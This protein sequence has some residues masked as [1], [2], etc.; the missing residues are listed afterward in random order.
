MS[1]TTDDRFWTCFDNMLDS[2]ALRWIGRE[3]VGIALAAGTQCVR[4]EASNPIPLPMHIAC[5][6]FLEASGRVMPPGLTVTASSYWGGTEMSAASQREQF[7]VNPYGSGIHTA[8]ELAPS[9]EL[10]FAPSSKPMVM[11]MFNRTDLWAWR[12]EWVRVVAEAVDGTHQ[13]LFDAQSNAQAWLARLG[14]ET[15]TNDPH[16]STQR[17]VSLGLIDAL[18]RGDPDLPR[19]PA[20]VDAL[21]NSRFERL[22]EAF[23]MAKDYRL[24]G[25]L[26]TINR[27][28]AMRQLEVA[29]HGVARTF[30]FL[31]YASKATLALRTAEVC[32]AL[33]TLGLRACAGYGTALGLI[34]GGDLIAHDDDMDVH[35]IRRPPDAGTNLK[36]FVAR[37]CQWLN[38]ALSEQGFRVENKRTHVQVRHEHDFDVFGIDVFP[39]LEID[40]D[41]RSAV[42]H[43]GPV[44]RSGSFEIE[45]ALYGR[46]ALPMPK[47]RETYCQ[48]V[49]GHDWRTPIA[50]Y[51]HTWA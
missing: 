41:L 32:A 28:A 9:I 36:E 37:E 49:Y 40:G 17:I 42:N 13:V 14:Q 7:V 8:L 21:W 12:N 10:R 23:L 20:A 29:A 45:S 25:E 1:P 24:Q 19:K 3:P 16:A 2:P 26:Q 50:T 33:Q 47:D 11:V 46:V 44:S 18:V 35:A 31:S 34:R 22:H 39:T 48:G 15:L 38:S 4:I 43:K 30:R 5:V 27:L 51:H 6:H